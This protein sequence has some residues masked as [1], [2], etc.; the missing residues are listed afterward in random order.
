MVALASPRTVPVVQDGRP[1]G[2]PPTARRGRLGARRAAVRRMRRWR[3]WRWRQPA[4]RTTAPASSP[5]RSHH[6]VRCHPGQRREHRSGLLAPEHRP[7]GSAGVAVSLHRRVLTHR[8]GGAPLGDRPRRRRAGTREPPTRLHDAP[9]HVL[10]DH[11]GRHGNRRS[12]LPWRTGILDHGY[13]WLQ[14]RCRRPRHRAGG[15]RGRIVQGLHHRG[16]ARRN[17]LAG[18]GLA[19]GWHRRGTRRT[20]LAQPGC[21]AGGIRR[22]LPA[23]R[24]HVAGILAASGRSSQAW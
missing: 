10:P 23:G 12:A 4:H 19:G 5:A 18:T 3:R 1:Q 2:S 20:T 24:L 7:P 16:P 6:L 14:P 17:R 13:R 8:T 11:L 15:S 9:A 21:M 22:G